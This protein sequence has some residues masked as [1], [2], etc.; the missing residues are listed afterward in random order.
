LRRKSA[1]LLAGSPSKKARTD[2]AAR[3]MV[4]FVTGNANKLKEVGY[5]SAARGMPPAGTQ[6]CTWRRIADVEVR[7]A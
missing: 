1:D 7:A 4:T 3:R 6:G 5:R 2:M